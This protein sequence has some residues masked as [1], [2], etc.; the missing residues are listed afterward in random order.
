MP[1]RRLASVLVLSL[2]ACRA[3][4][5]SASAPGQADDTESTADQNADGVAN[6]TP[7]EKPV[8]CAAT[9]R[10]WEGRLGSCLYEHGGCCY[11]TPAAACSA[12][13]CP[14][15]RCRILESSPAQLYCA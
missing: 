2:V 11:D 9:G 13:G 15:E 3:E 5:R 4:S 8:E 1:P 10:V 7:T 12:A 6:G 14:E